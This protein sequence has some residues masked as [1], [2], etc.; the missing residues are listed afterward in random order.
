MVIRIAKKTERKPG[1]RN[2]SSSVVVCMGNRRQIPCTEK[3]FVE[4]TI[5]LYP[6]WQNKSLFVKAN[7]PIA[8][9]KRH[10]FFP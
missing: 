3:E 10:C 7:L 4:L 6:L 9:E 8:A 5:N 2:K 1:L